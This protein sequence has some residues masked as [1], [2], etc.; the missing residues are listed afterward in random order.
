MKFFTR[1]RLAYQV[2]TTRRARDWRR[3]VA[4]CEKIRSE[5]TLAEVFAE[6]HRENAL[7]DEAARLPAGTRTTHVAERLA[8]QAR[9]LVQPKPKG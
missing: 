4:T 9:Q 5:A 7:N 6:V 8:A 1:L 2:L 3:V